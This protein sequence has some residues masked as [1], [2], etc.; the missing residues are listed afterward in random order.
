MY[1]LTHITQG[2]H[3]LWASLKQRFSNARY[4]GSARDIC[5]MILERNWNGTYFTTSTHHYQEF[6]ARDFGLVV[7]ALLAL[8]YQERVR[9]TLSY[10]L[11]KYQQAG[12]IRTTISRTGTPFSFPNTYS[13]DSTALFLYSLMRAQVHDTQFTQQIIDEYARTVLDEHGRVKP[14]HFSSMRDH[15]KHESSCYNHCMSILIARIAEKQKLTFPFSEQQLIKILDEY[16]TGTH[17]KDDRTTNE[18]TGDANTFPYWLGVGKDFDKTLNAL[19]EHQLLDP[20]PLKYTSKKQPMILPEIFVKGWQQ[21]TIWPMMGLLFLQILEKHDKKLGQHY[22]NQYKHLIEQHG[23]LYEVYRDKKPY[24]NLFYH[25][26]EGMIWAA[27]F[28]ICYHFRFVRNT[29]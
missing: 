23:T 19:R 20:F 28:L 29:S 27:N 8:G 21:N 10:A 5:R 22:R 26:D 13:P 2:L 17:Y 18:P 3:Y 24:Q 9:K 11:K 1:T 4:P 14:G 25:A 7:D 16:W 12:T 15:A 6:W